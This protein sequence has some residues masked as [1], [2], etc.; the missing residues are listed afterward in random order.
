MARTGGVIKAPYQVDCMLNPLAGDDSG[1]LEENDVVNGKTEVLSE[2]VILLNV[3]PLF[4]TY[5]KIEDVRN[6]K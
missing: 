3:T 1:R 6:K 4:Q 2:M 5:M